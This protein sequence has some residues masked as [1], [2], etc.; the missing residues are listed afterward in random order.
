M[1]AS[2]ACRYSSNPASIAPQLVSRR[3]LSWTRV[4]CAQTTEESFSNEDCLAGRWDARLSRRRLRVRV[5][6]R[7]RQFCTVQ[8]GAAPAFGDLGC[9]SNGDTDYRAASV[10][11]AF[12]RVVLFVFATGSVTFVRHLNL[13][14]QTY[15]MPRH[16]LLSPSPDPIFEHSPDCPYAFQA[17]VWV[18]EVVTV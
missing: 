5:P 6:P 2:S 4:V 1:R 13:A 8:P 14:C 7:S 18:R 9:S 16:W 12:L 11:R 17:I 10:I 3:L 15:R